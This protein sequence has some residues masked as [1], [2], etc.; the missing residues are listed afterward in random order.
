MTR[1]IPGGDVTPPG[2]IFEPNSIVTDI[3]PF[4]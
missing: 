2:R 4:G 3:E 1:E